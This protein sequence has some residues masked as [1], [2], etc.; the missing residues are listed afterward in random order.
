MPTTMA[1]SPVMEVFVACDD[2]DL[3]EELQIT[4][5]IGRVLQNICRGIDAKIIDGCKT[6]KQFRK[7]VKNILRQ[8]ASRINWLMRRA[9][10]KFDQTADGYRSL[11]WRLRMF[12]SVS[13][14]LA[15]NAY[16]KLLNR[17][18]PS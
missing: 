18:F 6:I 3:A 15:G 7:A 11:L 1:G 4:K 9:R 14:G 13:N 17:Y 2:G 5:S 12:H 8:D 10:E 16:E